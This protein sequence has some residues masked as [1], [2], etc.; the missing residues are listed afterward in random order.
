MWLYLFTSLPHS[1]LESLRFQW[2]VSCSNTLLGS[3]PLSHADTECRSSSGTMIQI[4]SYLKLI[5]QM[6]S[7]SCD[8]VIFYFSD[9]SPWCPVFPSQPLTGVDPQV[10]LVTQSTKV[11]PLMSR[12]HSNFRALRVV[13]LSL[14]VFSCVKVTHTF[15]KTKK[16][17]GNRTVSAKPHLLHVALAVLELIRGA[18]SLAR[19]CMCTVTVTFPFHIHVFIWHDGAKTQITRFRRF[20]CFS[21][22]SEVWPLGG[23]G[24]KSFKLIWWTCDFSNWVKLK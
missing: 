2:P 10:L 7:K 12:F 20:L 5:S 9:C 24:N 15:V 8:L 17:R 3:F 16:K 4:H 6:E 18:L 14:C 22:K 11:Q 19:L 23:S 21:N 1:Q 13:G